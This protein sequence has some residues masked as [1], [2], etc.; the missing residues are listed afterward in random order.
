MDATRLGNSIRALR[1]RQRLRQEDLGRTAGVSQDLVSMIER[2]QI[3][4]VR[5]RTVESLVQKLGAE[6]R[7]TLRWRGGDIDRLLDEGHAAL[8]GRVA[9]MLEKAGWSVQPEVTFAIYADRGSIDVLAWHAA[10]RSV[11]VVEVK[12]ELTSIE[13]TL[14]THDM[15]TRIALKVARERAGWHGRTVARLLVLPE[16]TTSR[17]RV[18]RHAS[19]I[20]RAYPL[21]GLAARAWLR[22]PSGPTG[23]LMFMPFTS[24]TRGRC[25]PISRRRVRNPGPS[26]STPLAS[27]P[28]PIRQ[29]HGR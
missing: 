8:M 6:L 20:A 5:L 11:L 19:L 21:A 3:D 28:G 26:S 18:A 17:R 27:P 7:V 15:K 16:S 9:S 29:V 22:A 4:G 13:E 24:T 12:T 23:L 10:T 1:I 25:G 14:R 2:G